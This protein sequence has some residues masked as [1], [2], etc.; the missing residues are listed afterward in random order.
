MAS[1]AGRMAEYREVIFGILGE[2]LVIGS[3]ERKGKFFKRHREIVL[4]DGSIAALD[5]SMDCQ[6]DAEIL[7]L[8]ENDEVTIEGDAYRFI[9]RLPDQGDESGKVILELGRIL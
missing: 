6:A 3:T 5:I 4:R 2:T 9:R 7:A 1:L 8:E